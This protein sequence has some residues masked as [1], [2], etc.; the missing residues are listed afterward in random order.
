[1]TDTIDQDIKLLSSVQK[2]MPSKGFERVFLNEDEVRVQHFHNHMN[3]LI[4]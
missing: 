3:Q 4:D 1:M 2:G